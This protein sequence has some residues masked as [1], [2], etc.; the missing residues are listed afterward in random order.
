M[1]QQSGAR[2]IQRLR[3]DDPVVRAAL[4]KFCKT[5]QILRL[6]VFG[7]VLRDDFRE[8]GDDPS[9]V[10]VLVELDPNH[11]PGWEYYSWGDELTEL[12]DRKTEVLTSEELSRHYRDR[13]FEQAVTLCERERPRIAE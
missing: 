7:S 1:P 9:D 11:I 12:W 13:V 2:L 3:L 4:H 8:G 10:D 5:H 6:S